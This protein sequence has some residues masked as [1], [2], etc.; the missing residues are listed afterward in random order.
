MY[1]D[2]LFYFFVGFVERMLM[3]NK[4]EYAWKAY[5]DNNI[6]TKYLQA[7]IFLPSAL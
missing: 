5:S 1:I 4:K 7:V 3:N 2:N 6:D